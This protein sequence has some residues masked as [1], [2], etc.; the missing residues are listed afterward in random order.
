MHRR[1]WLVICAV[2]GAMAVLLAAMA[3]WLAALALQ[4][5]PTT[6]PGAPLAVSDLQAARRLLNREVLREA[7]HGAPL[8]LSLTADQA[9]ALTQDMSARVLH[10]PAALIL[11]DQQAELTLSLPLQQTPLQVLHPLGAW[12]NVRARLHAPPSGPPVLQAVQVGD[13]SIPPALAL[14]VAEHIARTRG[15]D[16]LAALALAAIER[17]RL[18]PAQVSATVRWRPAL[19][20]QA[21]ALLVPPDMVDALSRYHHQLARL[22][23]EA[24]ATDASRHAPRW[25]RP[26]S[27]VLPALMRTAQQTSLAHALTAS[28]V[29]PQDAAARENRAVLVVLGLYVNRVSLATLVPAARDWP[30]LPS[31]PLTLQ[32]REDLAQH[33]LTSAALATDLGGRLSD[34][35]GTYKELLDAAPQGLGSG[36]SFNDLAADKAGVR[37]GRLAAHDPLTL[38]ARLASAEADTDL[39]P[40]VSDLPEFLT[41]TQLQQ[42]YGGIDTPAY[43]TL[44]H[45]IDQRI[46]QTPVLR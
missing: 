20:A 9:Q 28:S 7:F 34:L 35:I 36:F 21:S 8:T 44:M 18:N 39:L 2:I 16:Q 17:V 32:G 37:L 19:S 42:R 43:R 26:L 46:A 12:L 45:D 5:Q 15:M 30:A 31:R 29:P 38:Q 11:T 10:A 6:A 33:Y 14:W 27:D 40:D 4:S 41:A 25:D 1:P 13:L 22:L 3:L 23:S 24:P